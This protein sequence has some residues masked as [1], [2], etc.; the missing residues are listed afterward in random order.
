M[1]SIQTPNAK[2]HTVVRTGLQYSLQDEKWCASPQH[3][4]HGTDLGMRPRQPTNKVL[5][6]SATM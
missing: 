4:T 3:G 5:C 2:H 6:V 1:H